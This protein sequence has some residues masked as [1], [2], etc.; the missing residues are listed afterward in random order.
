MGFNLRDYEEVKD[1]IPRFWKEHPE[2]AIETEMIE[3]D[4][5]NYV[6][7]ATLRRT[8]GGPIFATGLAQETVGQGN[9]NKTSALENCET[10]AIGRA[11]ANAGFSSGSQRASRE[12]MAKAAGDGGEPS[13]NE[14]TE[15]LHRSAASP[16]ASTIDEMKP[17]ELAAAL[18]E[19]GL[20]VVGTVEEMRERLRA[21]AA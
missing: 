5:N 13:P 19:R 20:D 10:S 1:R 18:A 3:H 17:R 21:V 14:G 4:G 9:V 8:E 12:E 15:G 2:G 11:L 6:V 7:K 16:P